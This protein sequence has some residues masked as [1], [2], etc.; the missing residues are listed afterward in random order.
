MN[1]EFLLVSTSGD[2]GL[3]FSLIM[4]NF[5][6]II[7]GFLSLIQMENVLHFTAVAFG[8]INL[9]LSI[10]LICIKIK[11]ELKNKNKKYNND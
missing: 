4:V 11:K 7:S 6:A 10:V 8:V 1:N 3:N 5:L 9:A 2:S